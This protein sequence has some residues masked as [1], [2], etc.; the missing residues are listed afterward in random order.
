MTLNCY[1]C[2]MKGFDMKLAYALCMA[3]ILLCFSLAPSYQESFT[4]KYMRKKRNKLM[5]HA[6]R[7]YAPYYTNIKNFLSRMGRRIL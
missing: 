4:P 7:Q 5:R 6:R 2:L 1:D 3:V